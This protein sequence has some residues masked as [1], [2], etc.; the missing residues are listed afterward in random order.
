MLLGHPG[1]EITKQPLQWTLSYNENSQLT[2]GHVDELRLKPVSLDFL[3]SASLHKMRTVAGSKQPL[4]RALGKPEQKRVYDLTA[5]FGGDLLLMIAAGF[6][7]TA[8]EK[9]PLVFVLLSDAV[10][11]WK[12]EIESQGVPERVC[13]A[14]HSLQAIHAD[15]EDFVKSLH[16]KE[17]VV[18]YLDP[19]FEAKKKSRLSQGPMQWMQRLVSPSPHNSENL[20]RAAL[21]VERCRVVVK[22]S[23]KAEAFAGPIQ[24]RYLGTSVRYDMYMS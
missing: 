1:V 15:S 6:S 14:V 24:H 17:A 20:V 16:C 4:I 12:A 23:L 10:T 21:A 19:M 9:N 13:N 3:S 7:V 22:R 11:R 2:L 5:G 8:I 18:L